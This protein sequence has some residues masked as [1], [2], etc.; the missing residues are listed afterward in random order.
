M[1]TERRLTFRGASGNEL[2]GLLTSPARDASAV[3]LLVHGGMANK[4]SFYHKHLAQRLGDELGYCT[5]RYDMS[6]NGESVPITKP[7]SSEQARNMMGG[8]WEDVADLRVAVL[9]LQ[10]DRGLRVDCIVAHSRG[11]QV[12]HMLAARHGAELGIP[13]IA[14]ANMRFDL[15]YWR[16]TR[17]KYVA[18]EEGEWK[19][20]FKNRGKAA[21]HTVSEEDV[22]VYASVPMHEVAGIECEVLN[23]YGLLP[24]GGTS[25]Q[26]SYDVGVE[27]LTD[28]VV[29]FSD[30]EAPANLIRHHTLRFLPGVGHF[31]KEP[32]SSEKLFVALRDWLLATSP[33]PPSRARL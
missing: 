31:Y 24:P 20:Q 6:G 9:F 27:L 14:G 5:F 23:A 26:A 15:E 11:G 22:D 13:R 4:N 28:G 17:A 19:L 7:G 10:R 18:G 16:S 33:P 1:A 32:G 12:A 25:G 8:F 21:Q 3:V 2:V 30:C 29:P